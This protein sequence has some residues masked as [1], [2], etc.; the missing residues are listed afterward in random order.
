MNHGDGTQWSQH[1]HQQHQASYRRTRLTA[2]AHGSRAQ[3]TGSWQ[4]LA[5]AGRGKPRK[6]RQEK[7]FFGALPRKKRGKNPIMD[8]G[9]ARSV[10]PLDYGPNA[11]ATQT[12]V[13]KKLRSVTGHPAECHGEKT[14]RGTT[15]TAAGRTVATEMSFAATDV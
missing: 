15:V 5:A 9:A 13:P 10:C 7:Q 6:T 4:G 14:V 12:S 8:S 2:R 3:G 1:G 11:K